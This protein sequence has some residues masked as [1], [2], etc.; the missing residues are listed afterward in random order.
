ML[1]FHRESAR[2]Q[3]RLPD[4][5]T[6]VHVFPS[7]ELLSTARDFILN[8]TYCYVHYHTMTISNLLAGRQHTMLYS[9]CQ[10][11]ILMFQIIT[12]LIFC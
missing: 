5:S 3:F 12:P 6:V 8:V 4:A 11:V 1:L 9:I 2:I 10:C 7:S